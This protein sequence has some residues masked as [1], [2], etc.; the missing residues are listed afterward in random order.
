MPKRSWNV[1]VR[2][3]SLLCR[4]PAHKVADELRAGDPAHPP[5]RDQAVIR[6]RPGDLAFDPAS[7]ES[8][9][10]AFAADGGRLDS[11]DTSTM[12][13]Q[14]EGSVVIQTVSSSSAS[15]LGLLAIGI[16]AS[17]SSLSGSMRTTVPSPSV[18][19]QTAPESVATA[20]GFA[21]TRIV[22]R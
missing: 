20:A 16:V 8:G 4:K 15:A 3:P 19:T 5:I 2:P 1:Y 11:Q 13:R 18:V 6:E 9:V 17:I 21:P 7:G 14:G 22:W 10:D 12:A